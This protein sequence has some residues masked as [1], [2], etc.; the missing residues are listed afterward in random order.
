M[1]AG[2]NGFGLAPE[3]WTVGVIAVAALVTAAVLATRRRGLRPGVLWALA[4]IVL[5]RSADSSRPR[6]GSCFS[7][8][9]SA[10]PSWPPRSSLPWSRSAVRPLKS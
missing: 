4:G 7:R 9:R 6:A 2:W 1:T 5:K 3:V 8:P 10:G